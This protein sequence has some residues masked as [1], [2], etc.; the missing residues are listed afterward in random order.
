MTIKVKSTVV[1]EF[2]NNIDQESINSA[3]D[4]LGLNPLNNN[5]IKIA[6]LHIAHHGALVAYAELIARGTV[7]FQSSVDHLTTHSALV[8]KEL[9]PKA[10]P[11]DPDVRVHLCDSCPIK[12]DYGKGKSHIYSCLHYDNDKK[13]A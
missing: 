8:I 10:P 9:F 7:S 3:C 6:K 11:V 5:D 12:C 13:G 1:Q 2:I 4:D